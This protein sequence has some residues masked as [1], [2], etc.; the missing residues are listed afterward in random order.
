M[1]YF[2][3]GGLGFSLEY[4]DTH[5]ISYKF[6]TSRGMNFRTFYNRSILVHIPMPSLYKEDYTSNEYGLTYKPTLYNK[7]MSKLFK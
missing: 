4:F 1:K 3:I 5:N 7:I 2:K 6:F